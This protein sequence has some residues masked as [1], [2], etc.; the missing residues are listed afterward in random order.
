MLAKKTNV[1]KLL[2][3]NWR[4]YLNESEDKMDT[5]RVA[6]VVLYKDEKV[7]LLRSALGDFKEEWDLPGGHVEEGEDMLD[8]L[9]REVEEETGLALETAEALNFTHGHKTFYRAPLPKGDIKLSDEHDQQSMYN[10]KE[11]GDM[12]IASYF[13]EAIEKAIRIPK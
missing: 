8:G 7:L 11:L 9:R 4:K 1:M 5:K 13:K 10:V 6:K 12:K 3:E 2:L